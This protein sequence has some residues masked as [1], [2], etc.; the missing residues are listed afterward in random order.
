MVDDSLKR[1]SNIGVGPGSPLTYAEWMQYHAMLKTASELMSKVFNEVA[2]KI[3][4]DAGLDPQLLGIHPHNAM[5]ALENGHPWTEVDYNR[6]KVVMDLLS[7]E[8]DGSRIVE[9][10]DKAVRLDP[11]DRWR[12]ANL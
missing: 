9:A 3:S 2:R 1:D 8:F 11:H 6:V 12:E 7:H 5:C 10:F 4:G